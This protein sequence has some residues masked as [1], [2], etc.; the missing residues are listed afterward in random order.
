[1]RNTDDKSGILALNNSKR[2]LISIH[3]LGDNGQS[4]QAFVSGRKKTLRP[5]CKHDVELF[6]PLNLYSGAKRI[7]PQVH[8]EHKS[9]ET[10]CLAGKR[11]YLTWN[12]I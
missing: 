2:R 9:L 8:K 10:K 3:I 11:T 6:A 12:L 4:H 5:A 7:F 1:M